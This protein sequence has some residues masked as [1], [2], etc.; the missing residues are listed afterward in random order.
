MLGGVI[1]VFVNQTD[2]NR[3]LL[4]LGSGFV[5]G[6]LSTIARRQGWDVHGVDSNEKQKT[7]GVTLHLLDITN[8]A[9]LTALIE[10]LRPTAVVDLAAIADI[11][12]AERER[13]LAWAVNVEA[14][15]TM[16]TCCARASAAACI[17]FSSDAVF[18]GT[19]ASY[20]EED[21]PDPVN[22]YGKTKLEGERAV[23]AA[24]PAATIV[25][26]SLVLGFPVAAVGN[27]FFAGL[28]SKLAEKREIACP[29]DEIRTPVDVITLGECIM[30]LLAARVSGAIHIGSIDSID[31]FT[32][33]Q[34]VA[35]RM[36][37]PTDGI[38]AQTESAL[39]AGRAKRHKNGI[40]RVTKA[41]KLLR[42]PL[43]SVEDSI[44]RAFE[45]RI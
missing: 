38:I 23:M 34:K 39:P 32:L 19:S 18:A 3:T 31:R 25:R 10:E 30:E 5:G 20:G 44:R 36:G 6:N 45:E 22:W 9:A 37:Y 4:I 27:S 17:Y 29:T 40:I 42:T 2:S 43:R 7:A 11:D 15:R 26:L 28:E 14:A 33:T 21:A 24:C 41:Q 35:R 16:A 12:R 1:L 8:A 13:D